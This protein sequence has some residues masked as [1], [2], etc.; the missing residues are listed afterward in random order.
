MEVVS[1]FCTVHALKLIRESIIVHVHHKNSLDVA[2]KTKQWRRFQ[3][4]VAPIASAVM[5][6]GVQSAVAG[7]TEYGAGVDNICV[8]APVDSALV[9]SREPS[10]SEVSESSAD[11]RISND[12]LG[13]GSDFGRNGNGVLEGEVSESMKEVWLERC[14]QI[15][16]HPMDNEVKRRKLMLL[17]YLLRSPVFDRYTQTNIY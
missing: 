13:A 14:A 5:P 12:G 10:A 7:S 9:L 6:S 3:K 2:K 11:S 15:A 1:I 8:G 17:L 16:K 4:W